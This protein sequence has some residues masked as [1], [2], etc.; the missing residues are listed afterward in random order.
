MSRAAFSRLA[1]LMLLPV[2]WV[3]LSGATA[4]DSAQ[5]ARGKYLV[6][7]AGCG[8]CHTP[9]HFSGKEDMRRYLAGSDV[10]LS[11]PD[12][13][14]VV[15]SNLT[16]DPAT[17]LGKWS[18][19]DI[20]R[21]LKSGVTPDGRVLSPIMPWAN[22]NHLTRADAHAIAVFLKSLPPVR[23]RV[24]GPFAPGKTPTIAHISLLH[25]LPPHP[26]GC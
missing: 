24:P 3:L 17:G 13:S 7:I 4:G 19:A 6:E 16:P 20:V 14:T 8:D 11:L 23:H 22:F 12:G 25:R 5:L 15:G 10:G 2:G 18:I 21:A 9:G 26:C 1:A